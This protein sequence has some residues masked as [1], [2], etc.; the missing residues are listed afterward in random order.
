R[1]ATFTDR[2][3]APRTATSCDVRLK[4]VE[5]AA[6]RLRDGLEL[7]FG[8]RGLLPAPGLAVGALGH[9]H[10]APERAHDRAV[11]L[12]AAGLDV[13][14]AAVVLRPGLGLVQHLGLAV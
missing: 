4:W 5:S 9:H 1:R 11:L 3:R 7:R 13:D 14:D 2:G 6:R 10:L 12:V 8:P